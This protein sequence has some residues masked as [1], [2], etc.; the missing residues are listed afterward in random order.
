VPRRAPRRR[1]RQGAE[2]RRRCRP[3][4]ASPSARG[5]SG[6]RGAS[7]GDR[8]RAERRSWFGEPDG[9]V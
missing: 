7:A 4:S 5:R 1:H 9:D 2:A 3:A 6:P 8:R